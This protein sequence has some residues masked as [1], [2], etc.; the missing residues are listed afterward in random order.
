MGGPLIR[1]GVT[2]IAAWVG[3]NRFH[4]GGGADREAA[5]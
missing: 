4:R 2:L 3:D 1:L 5:E